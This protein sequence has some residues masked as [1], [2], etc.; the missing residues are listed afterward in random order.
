MGSGA[1][2]GKCSKSR[3]WGSVRGRGAGTGGQGSQQAPGGG[4]RARCCCGSIA[5]WAVRRRNPRCGLRCGHGQMQQKQAVGVGS[6]TGRRHRRAGESASTRRG[7]E[8]ALLLW[9]HR[10][11]GG[12]AP[13]SAMWARAPTWANAAKAGGGGRFG[14][15]SQAQAGRGVSRHQEG[16]R[17]R[18]VVV[19]AASLS[20]R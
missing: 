16:A 12:E 3:R 19:V 20:G 8:S 18:V 1:G 5:Q 13:E 9:Q 7:L 14:G 6:G 2:M 11:V 4:S 10:S 15:G 17:E